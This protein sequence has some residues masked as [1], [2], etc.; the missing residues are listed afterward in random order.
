MAQDKSPLKIGEG[1]RELLLGCGN[2]R[3]KHL[4][5]EPMNEWKN[6]TTLDVSPSCNPDVVWDLEQT[7]WPFEDS[8]FD[9]LH[10]YEVMEHLGRQGDWK[11]FFRIWGEVDRILKVGGLFFG[12]SPT[13]DSP[14]AWG[15][16]GHTQIISPE[17][18]LFLSQEQYE[19]EVGKGPMTDY[20]EVWKGNLHIIKILPLGEG[21]EGYVLKKVRKGDG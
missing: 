1:Y 4:W 10:A 19:R 17:K 2:R 20:R 3:T 14:W 18:L 16:P 7:P 21:Q 8:S 13:F 15:D 11:G 6:L 12:S 9:E 5:I